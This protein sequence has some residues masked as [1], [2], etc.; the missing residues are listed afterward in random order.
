MPLPDYQESLTRLQKALAKAWKETPHV[1]NVPGQSVLCKLDPNYCLV[2][3]PIFT[4]ILA[5]WAVTFPDNV[6][7]TLKHTGNLVVNPVVRAHI[8]PL[9][10]TWSGQDFEVQAGFVLSEFVDRALKLYG[11]AAEPLP[12]SDLRI[13][14]AEKKA[15]D[16][17]FEGKTAPGAVAFV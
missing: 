3:E 4:E 15:V 9:T 12:V 6:L 13:R 7:N 17:F 14:L 11:G 10:I 16:A 2:L 5:R 1:L 8:L